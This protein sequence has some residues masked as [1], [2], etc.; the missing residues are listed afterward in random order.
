[1]A[2][3]I[4]RLVTRPSIVGYRQQIIA[5]TRVCTYYIV[6]LG[7]LYFVHRSAAGSPIHLQHHLLR[8]IQMQIKKVGGIHFL[9]IGRFGASFYVSKA[10]TDKTPILDVLTAV[11][12]GLMFATFLFLGI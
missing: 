12:T 6:Y 1:M 2:G 4:A 7:A 3:Q 10:K 9:K 11:A 8:G 5:D